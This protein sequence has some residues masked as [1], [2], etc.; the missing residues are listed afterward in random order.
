MQKVSHTVSFLSLYD[1]CRIRI[2]F[3]VKGPLTAF[4]FLEQDWKV[5]TVDVPDKHDLHQ[6][7][8]IA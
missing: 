7:M 2:D 8:S 6:A 1:S 3:T 5:R 4:V